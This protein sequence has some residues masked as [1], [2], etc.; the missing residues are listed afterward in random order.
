MFTD[1]P[2]G[3]NRG[4]LPWKLRPLTGQASAPGESAAADGGPFAKTRFEKQRKATVMESQMEETGAV[5]KSLTVRVDGAALQDEKRRALDSLRGQVNLK[6]FRKGKVPVSVLQKMYGRQ[7]HADAVRKL[8]GME[9]SKLVQG[10]ED[11]IHVALPELVRDKTEDGGVEFSVAVEYKPQIEVKG[12]VGLAVERPLSEVSDEEV[13]A[14]IERMR[15]RVGHLEAIEDRQVVE[16]GDMAFISFKALEDG[17]LAALQADNI[18]IKVGAGH[19]LDGL[20]EGLVGC[21]LGEAKEI[22]ITVPS[23]PSFPTRGGQQAPCEVVVHEIKREV[24]PALDDDFALDTGEA[25]T[26]EDLRVAVAERLLNQKR[27]A[28]E[29]VVHQAILAKLRMAHPITPPWGHIKERAQQRV[30]AQLRSM[31]PNI[32][33]E[34]L[35]AM[36]QRMGSDEMESDLTDFHNELLLDAVAEREGITVEP[37]VLEERAREMFRSMNMSAAQAREMMQQARV[38]DN[39]SEMVRRELTLKFLLAGAQ[40][41]EVAPQVEESEAPD[42]SAAPE[43]E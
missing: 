24:L 8:A 15:Q 12:Y 22:Q 40:V 6:G 9:I 36:M 18:Q 16:D 11:I 5:S 35:D 20:E 31:I 28:T 41:T 21:Q 26:Y 2:R 23:H 25:E 17:E 38:R 27:K 30:A 37:A 33:Q 10:Q 32:Q 13:D 7:V 42:P 34:M 14:E 1:S 19:A 29:S 3:A 39:V 4:R 43:E